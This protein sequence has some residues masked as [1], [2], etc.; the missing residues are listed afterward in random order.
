MIIDESFY[1]VTQVLVDKTNAELDWLE[2]QKRRLK[3]KDDQEGVASLRKRQRALLAKLQTEQ[4]RCH[5]HY[6][7]CPFM[8]IFMF[9]IIVCLFYII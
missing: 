8:F 9:Y 6:T 7:I 2:H 1:T 5:N 4:V 3:E